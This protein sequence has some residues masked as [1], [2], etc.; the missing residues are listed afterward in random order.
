MCEI[1]C[2]T[3]AQQRPA[4][5]YPIVPLEVF[6]CTPS[7][8]AAA[9]SGPA[10]PFNRDGLL[11]YH[12]KGFYE[13]GISPV[14]MIWKDENC[15]KYVINTS[16]KPDDDAQRVVLLVDE[17]GALVTLEKKQLGQL[18][19]DHV[20]ALKVKPGQFLRFRV[21]RTARVLPLIAAICPVCVFFFVFVSVY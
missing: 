16:N 4:N 20:L 15:S 11:F 14:A 5:K 6:P 10:V 17:K 21:V 18:T 2:P 7:G 12:K 19:H 3:I 1:R 9:Y 8:L 13:P